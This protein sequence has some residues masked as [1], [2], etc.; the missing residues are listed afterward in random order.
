MRRLARVSLLVLVDRGL[1]DFSAEGRLDLPG[2]TGQRNGRKSIPIACR[3]PV[4][5]RPWV[6]GG[7]TIADA[8]LDRIGHNACCIELKGGATQRNRPP[9]LS[10]GGA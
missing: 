4:D 6:I 7:P 10:G 1:E 5:C 8:I 3:I 9:P 2:T